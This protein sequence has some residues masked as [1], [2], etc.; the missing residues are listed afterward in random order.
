MSGTPAKPLI[1]AP[2][3]QE[4]IQAIKALPRNE[5]D[6]S[7]QATL[8]LNSLCRT[9]RP[10]HSGL[11]GAFEEVLM[12]DSARGKLTP[13]RPSGRAQPDGRDPGEDHSL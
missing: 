11:I 5:R 2:T 13:Y 7:Q 4:R 9:S 12:A 8:V 6:A 10:M 1:Q 3:E